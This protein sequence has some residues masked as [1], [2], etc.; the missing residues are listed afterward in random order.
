MRGFSPV[1][2]TDQ[3]AS[4]PTELSG[5]A[6]SAVQPSTESARYSISEPIGWSGADQT[7]LRDVS[8]LLAAEL[9]IGVVY[10]VVG[11]L[12]LRFM[13]RESRQRASIQIA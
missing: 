5:N 11:Y 1:S 13:E 9:A 10:T 7:S 8:G 2:V 4:H 12:A 3:V 6:R